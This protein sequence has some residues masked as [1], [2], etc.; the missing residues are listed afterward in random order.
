MSKIEELFAAMEDQKKSRE[1]ATEGEIVKID[2]GKIGDWIP[3]DKL[4]KPEQAERDAIQV[5]I[6]VPDGYNIKKVLTVS[7]HP[8][9]ALQRYLAKY[10]GYPKVGGMYPVEYSRRSGFWEGAQ[11]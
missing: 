1:A 9:S 8:N 4:N 10:K 3:V 5:N 11:L 6:R 7:S 2:V